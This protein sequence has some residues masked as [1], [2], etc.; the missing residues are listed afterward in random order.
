[1]LTAND[2]EDLQDIISG[3]TFLCLAYMAALEN[4][5]ESPSVLFDLIEKDLPIHRTI[6]QSKKPISIYWAH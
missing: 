3:E 2:P 4:H 1:M 5:L 6:K